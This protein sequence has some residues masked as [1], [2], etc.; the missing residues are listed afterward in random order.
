[1]PDVLGDLQAPTEAICQWR[2]GSGRSNPIRLCLA[3]GGPTTTAGDMFSGFV[4]G[5]GAP[6]TFQT[7]MIAYHINIPLK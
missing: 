5:R 4:R 1:M 3:T 7:Q 2:S 6:D